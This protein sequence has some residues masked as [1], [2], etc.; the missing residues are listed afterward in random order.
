[1]KKSF[2][3]VVDAF[4]E[5]GL[6]AVLTAFVLFMLILYPLTMGVLWAFVGEVFNY[7]PYVKDALPYA[8][9]Q[10]GLGDFYGKLDYLGF[11]AGVLM[12]YL[13][14]LLS[15]IRGY[16]IKQFTYSVEENEEKQK[17]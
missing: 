7:L 5:F 6:A 4:D 13:S 15:E 1:M 8:L 9:K 14:I 11:F 3:R 10:L 12:A 17:K 16:S 2:E